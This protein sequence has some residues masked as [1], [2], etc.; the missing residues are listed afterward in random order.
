MNPLALILGAGAAGAAL[1]AVS[2]ARAKP[3]PLL[4]DGT[5]SINVKAAQ[6]LLVRLG[7]R[8]AIDGKFGPNT[9]QAWVAAA[10]ERDLV[11]KIIGPTGG[12]T[13]EVNEATA[14]ALAAAAAE[15]PPLQLPKPTPKPK[16]VTPKPA[17]Q[18]TPD[19]AL[20]ADRLL[21]LK[22]AQE[23][24]ALEEAK[25]AEAKAA[26]IPRHEAINNAIA[27]IDFVTPKTPAG[28]RKSVT[29]L[30]THWADQF[31]DKG[32]RDEPAKLDAY[33]QWYTRAW[34]LLPSAV[35]AKTV[36]PRTID[37]T[38]AQESAKTMTAP[39]RDVQNLLRALG[40]NLT[41]DGKYGPATQKAWENA[42]TARQLPPVISAS[43]ASNVSVY[44][45][46][47]EKLTDE[48]VAKKAAA[49]SAQPAQPAQ[50]PTLTAATKDVQNVLRLLGAGI[51]ADGKY[52]PATQKAWQ[53]AAAARQ[54]APQITGSA[55]AATLTVVRA[56]LEKLTTEAAARKAAATPAPAVN[57]ET[58]VIPTLRAQQITTRHGASLKHDGLW[59]PATRSAWEK[60]A[61]THHVSVRFEKASTDGKQVRVDAQALRK[62]DGLPPS[63]AATAPVGYDRVKAK[64][65]AKEVATKL[66][67][68]GKAYDRKYLAGWQT[69]AGLGADGLYGPQTRNALVYYGAS[70]APAAYVKG[71]D[72]PYTPPA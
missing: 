67:Q 58:I 62:L 31:W 52:G 30:A 61:T 9:A 51:A 43:G 38:F 57:A 25:I 41:A 50:P 66:R 6:T 49:S 4:G 17:P 13:A 40:A 63:G 8:I 36:H 16:P 65:R 39:T 68:Q 32:H 10:K 18:P 45:S 14:K 37:P 20:E 22:A 33:A 5:T 34:K 48:A 47:L 46:T 29:D 11:W 2:K 59:G 42:A 60:L 12:S 55:G 35:Q 64:A 56:T 54:L 53:D 3:K 24:K 15:A 44:R 71:T 72:R 7:A 19:A 21:A 70:D 1:F 26:S 23:A 28:T 69:Q 27:R